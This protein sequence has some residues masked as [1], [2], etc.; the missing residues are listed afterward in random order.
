M[1]I[2]TTNERV[3]GVL[4]GLC[5]AMPDGYSAATLTA[6]QIGGLAAELSQERYR[7][8]WALSFDDMAPVPLD[9]AGL[10]E[11]MDDR[12]AQA[13]LL[14]PG[15]IGADSE[16]ITYF[17]EEVYRQ[18][19]TQGNH[20]RVAQLFRL[21]YAWTCPEEYC[22]PPGQPPKF[23]ALS[24]RDTSAKRNLRT[25]KRAGNMNE[26]L[27]RH[28]WLNAIGEPSRSALDTAFL[29]GVVEMPDNPAAETNR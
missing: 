26:L 21:W 9:Y 25:R 27:A 22:N 8:Q 28:G 4:A 2:T 20:V 12:T 19:V 6:A 14:A 23:E 17:V 15:F 13:F 1:L 11:G 10:T 18:P 24:L 29:N 16:D 3:R 5:M 7:G